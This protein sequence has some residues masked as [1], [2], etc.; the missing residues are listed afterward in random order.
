M[1]LFWVLVFG[2]VIYA[3]YQSA[4]VSGKRIGS[5]KAYGVGYSRGLR[6]SRKNE[7]CLVIIVA[8]LIV[9]GTIAIAATG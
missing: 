8:T 6:K 1:S 5:R 3:V 4:F 7:G 9:I 2:V